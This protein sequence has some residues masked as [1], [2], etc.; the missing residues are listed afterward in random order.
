MKTK[1]LLAAVL[2]LLFV[3]TGCSQSRRFGTQELSYRLAA[4]NETYAFSLDGATLS[5]GYYHIPFSVHGENDMLLSCEED[6]QGQLLQILLTA[7]KNTAPTGEFIEL[8]ELLTQIF[9]G[10]SRHDAQAVLHEAGLTGED[11]LFSDH[12][13]TVENGRYSFTFYSTPISIT[14]I[15]HYD[16][17]VVAE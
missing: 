7:E 5:N 16:D 8:S 3:C 4:E 6:A 11:V 15:L 1:N 9:F 17:A 14:V 12:T 10:I 2:V 13:A